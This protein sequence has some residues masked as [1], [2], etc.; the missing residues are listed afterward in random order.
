MAMKNIYIAVG[1]GVITTT[2]FVL[3]IYLIALA[4]KEGGE[5]GLLHRKY[6]S[7]RVP[8]AQPVPQIPLDAYHLCVFFRHRNLELAYTSISILYGTQEL[9]T[10]IW[11]SNNTR[12]S[13][14]SLAFLTVMFLAARLR[15]QGLKVRTIMQTI[16]ADAMRY[17]MVIFSAHLVLVLTLNLAPVRTM[18]PPSGLRPIPSNASLVRI[19]FNFCQARKSYASCSPHKPSYYPLL[20]QRLAVSQCKSYIWLMLHDLQPLF[21]R[22]LPVMIS[23][24]MLSL[25]KAADPQQEAWTLMAPN[26]A[27]PN[28]QGMQF[29]RPRR[30]ANGRQLEIIPLDTYAESQIGI[31]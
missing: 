14:D 7:L 15:F 24:I 17:F 29:F 6:S 22:Y 16:A 19:R 10:C 30:D 11:N 20:S 25:K 31:R 9:S 26:A 8:V 5:G 23:R 4:R 2:Q 13:S 12:G 28:P 27:G 21:F 1:F 18:V 3:G